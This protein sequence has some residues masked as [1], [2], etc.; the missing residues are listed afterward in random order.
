MIFPFI[1]TTSCHDNQFLISP[2]PFPTTICLPN[3]GS[4]STQP[5]PYNTSQIE[6][7]MSHILPFLPN[8]MLINQTS[9][10]HLLHLHQTTQH[11]CLLSNLNLFINQ[12]NHINH[13]LTLLTIIAISLHNHPQGA[14]ILYTMFSYI[15]ASHLS[16]TITL[17]PCHMRLSLLVTRIDAIKAEIEAFV[18]N[19]NRDIHH[20]KNIFF[21]AVLI[22]CQK[23]Y[24]S[25]LQKS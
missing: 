11:Y 25:F 3:L 23:Y 15:L 7:K 1:K 24:N 10:S 17:C 6:P 19:K 20:K 16:V 9:I 5:T 18:M 2:T 4:L 21:V 12:P 22:N 14:Y 13:P 8:T